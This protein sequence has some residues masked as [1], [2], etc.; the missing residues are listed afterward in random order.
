MD[1]S[2]RPSVLLGVLWSLCGL[3]TSFTAARFYSR[4]VLEPAMGWDDW[5]MLAALVRPHIRQLSMRVLIKLSPGTELRSLWNCDCLGSPRARNPSEY[6]EPFGRTLCTRISM[7]LS[8][9]CGLLPHAF[10]GF[11]L[12]LAHPALSTKD[13]Y[14]MDPHHSGRCQRYRRCAR[15]HFDLYTMLTHTKAMGSRN[16]GRALYQPQCAKGHRALEGM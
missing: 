7:G 6:T 12:D 5:S 14:E 1:V 3:G 8:S 16:K 15:G 10:T 13:L 9:V 4:M 11:G 2:H